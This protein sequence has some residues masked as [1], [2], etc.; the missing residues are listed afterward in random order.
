MALLESISEN[1]FVSKTEYVGHV[2]ISYQEFCSFNMQ[3][4]Y[5]ILHSCTYDGFIFQ[6][7]SCTDV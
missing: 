7:C 5:R 2:S 4:S 3:V 1:T 6:Y